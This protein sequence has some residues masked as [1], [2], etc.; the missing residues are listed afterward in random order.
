[1]KSCIAYID[2]GSRGNPGIAGYGVVVLDEHRNTLAEIS[3]S[4]GIQTNNYAEYTAFIGALR[5]ATTH[6]YDSLRVYA[7]S[8]LLVRQI[9]GQYKIRNANLKGLYDQAQSLIQGLKQFSIQ[10]IP[11]EKNQDADRL[12][13]LA[14]DKAGSTDTEAP[15]P[16]KIV[17]AVFKSG[18]FHPLHPLSLPDGAEFQLT[19]EP[20]KKRLNQD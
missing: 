19:V 10:H 6:Q 2:G 18:C 12:A 3:E 5:Y 9:N 20:R 15:P 8:E 13:N 11:R 17:R 7:D 4:V 1:M 14:M 16:L